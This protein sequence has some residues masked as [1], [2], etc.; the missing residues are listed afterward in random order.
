MF[1][2]THL[3]TC[4]YGRYAPTMIC[5]TTN[6][7]PLRNL[8]IEIVPCTKDLKSSDFACDLIE[9]SRLIFVHI[10]RQIHSAKILMTLRFSS[11][12]EPDKAV[13][14]FRFSSIFI[15]WLA[16]NKPV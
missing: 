14:S 6:G 15:V 7:V 10:P 11:S 12:V 5:R 2:V 4:M 8:G 16:S 9:N 3:R 13:V 1:T